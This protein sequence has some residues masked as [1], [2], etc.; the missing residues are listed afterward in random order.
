MRVTTMAA[1]DFL[2]C[3]RRLQQGI[4]TTAPCIFKDMS[5]LDESQKAV[6]NVDRIADSEPVNGEELLR[7][8]KLKR[9]LREARDYLK[10]AGSADKPRK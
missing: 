1:S 4:K 3:E 2:E 10:S 8:D 7:S 6:R 9:L 5:E